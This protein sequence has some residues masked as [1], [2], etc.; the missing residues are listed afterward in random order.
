MDTPQ[1]SVCITNI[2]T[3]YRN[4]EVRSLLERWR[5]EL[6]NGQVGNVGQ[7]SMDTVSSMVTRVDTLDGVLSTVKNGV[8]DL[9]AEWLLIKREV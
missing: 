2:S 4:I 9:K 7:V 6:Q 8:G 1:Q 5:Q 3:I